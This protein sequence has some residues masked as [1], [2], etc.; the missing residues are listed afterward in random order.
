MPGCAI[1]LLDACYLAG[2]VDEPL[3]GVQQRF[4]DGDGERWAERVDDLAAAYADA[5]DVV[6]GAAVHSVRA[7]PPDQLPAVV[8]W[9]A[10][11]TAPL[12]VHVSEQL[13]ENEA[14]VAAYGR[15]PTQLLDE[16]GAL[17]PRTTAV[18]ATHLTPTDVALLGG[19]GTTVCL[20]PTTER[21]LADG[22]GPGR[23]LADAGSALAVGSDSQAV[24]DPFEELRGIE[25]HERLASGRRG[26]FGADEL[27]TAGTVGGHACLGRPDAGVIAAGARADLVTVALDGSVRTA[28]V[29]AAG[30]RGG[31]RR[32]R[33]RRHRRGGRPA[34]RVVTAGTAPA[35]RCAGPL[36][37][38][39]SRR[40]GVSAVTAVA[41][42][43]IGQLVTADPALGDGSRSAWCPT[44]RSSWR[45]SRWC[46]PARPLGLR[47]PTRPST[48]AGGRSCRGSSTRTRTWSSPATARAE[49]EARMTG[50]RVRG[51]RH[52]HARWRRPVR[53]PTSSW[54]RGPGRWWPRC[55]GRG[56][57]RSRSRAATG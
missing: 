28:G 43:G 33:R 5:D 35:G 20:C 1:T 4:G 57:R 40:R 17:G 6:V 53:P 2:G 50:V 14:C 9:A 52:P 45:A 38:T 32:H 11:R 54:P 55:C 29:G 15:T 7:V 12:H 26:H 23:A 18:H 34:D 3:G 24:V 22:I 51:G 30:R 21:E 31:V 10:H 19:S 25:L 36:S 16:A 49:F 48:S 8:G 39:P 37:P 13:A 27:L 44:R 56:P 46:G 42:T 41:L 47:A